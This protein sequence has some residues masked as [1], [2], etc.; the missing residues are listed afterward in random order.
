MNYRRAGG[1]DTAKRFRI[2]I[3]AFNSAVAS[4]ENHDTDLYLPFK[5]FTD[6]DLSRLQMYTSGCSKGR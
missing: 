2:A 3:L 4:V 1:I 6:V 5:V